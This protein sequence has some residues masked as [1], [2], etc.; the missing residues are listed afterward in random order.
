MNVH[1]DLQKE[2]DQDKGQGI[3]FIKKKTWTKGLT[4]PWKTEFVTST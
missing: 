1:I 4:S 3:D 2:A